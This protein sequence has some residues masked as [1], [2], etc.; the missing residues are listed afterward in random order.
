MVQSLRK[1]SLAEAS[2]KAYATSL[3]QWVA[4][5]RRFGYPSLLQDSLPSKRDE[6]LSRFCAYMHSYG[7]NVSGTGNS[8]GTILNKLAAIKWAH[9]FVT[10]TPLVT[11]DYLKMTLRGIQKSSKCPRGKTP[12]SISTLRAIYEG[13]R[14]HKRPLEASKRAQ[15]LWG[16]I[17]LSF[18]FMLRRS[19]VVMGDDLTHRHC[20]SGEDLWCTDS[21]GVRTETISA[22]VSVNIRV[23]SSKTDQLGVGVVRRLSLSGDPVL[24]P[25]RAAVWIMQARGQ[26]PKILPLASLGDQCI[27]Y[28]D[29][30]QAMKAGARRV[31]LPPSEFST[32]SLRAGGATYL[33]ASG[34]ETEVIMA[35]GRWKSDAVRRYIHVTQ[36]SLS[37]LARR[38]VSGPSS[39]SLLN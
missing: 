28:T 18:F 34:V 22:M 21:G 37:P 2:A 24:C 33:S 25:V 10:G 14:L 13:L 23:T 20:L 6:I 30:A 29:L 7:C 9:T 31:G 17:A 1:R 16:L 19:E 27:R 11:G 3:G 12:V 4:W 38:M 8:Y 32:H 5:T 35:L 15:L 26:A 39:L 36:C